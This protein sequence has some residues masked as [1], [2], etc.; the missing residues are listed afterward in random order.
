VACILV[1]GLVHLGYSLCLQRGY[2]VA[3]LS[4]VYPVARGSGPMLS[5]LAAFII[6]GE[7]PTLRGT[8][9]LIAVVGG[10]GLIS[11]QGSLAAFRKPGG[12]T[13]VRWGAATGGLIASYTVVDGYGVRALGIAP[14]VLD[15]ADPQGTGRW[16]AHHRMCGTHRRRP[17]AREFAAAMIGQAHGRQSRCRRR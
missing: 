5:T 16:L 7:M 14:V 11:T 1:S 4:V 3:D 13:G 6:F 9:G 10:I 8:L 15:C 2:Q 17:A 12:Q